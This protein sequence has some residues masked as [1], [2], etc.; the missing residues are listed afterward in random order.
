MLIEKTSPDIGWLNAGKI[1]PQTRIVVFRICR[2][3]ARRLKL[4]D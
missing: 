4:N 1:F 2:D 3:A